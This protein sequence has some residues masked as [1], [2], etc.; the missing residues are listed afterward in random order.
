MM[1]VLSTTTPPEAKTTIFEESVKNPYLWGRKWG[2][3]NGE[4]R[5]GTGKG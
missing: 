3:G 1:I 2:V 4:W 5:I